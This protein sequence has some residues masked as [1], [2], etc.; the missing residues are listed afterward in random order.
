MAKSRTGDVMYSGWAICFF[1]A[2][3]LWPF[4]A[5]AILRI[6]RRFSVRSLLIATTLVA[7]GLGLIV[8]A[9]RD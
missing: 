4:A 1:L 9:T 2:L 6:G 5:W 7:M 3:A 8:Y